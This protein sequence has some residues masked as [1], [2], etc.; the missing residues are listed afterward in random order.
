MAPHPEIS[1]APQAT[2]GKGERERERK[3]R[4][5]GGGEEKREGTIRRIRAK[6]NRHIS[7]TSKVQK[8]LNVP[9]GDE[10]GGS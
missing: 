9:A 7:S 3:G 2:S 8:N 4:N 5:A 10:A 1:Y 6:H